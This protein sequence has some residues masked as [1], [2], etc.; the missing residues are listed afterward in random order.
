M[1]YVEKWE[2]ARISQNSMKFK[3][4]EDK[5]RNAISDY[6]NK[7]ELENRIHGE[8]TMFL[9]ETLEDSFEEL[10]KWM[11]RYD[12]DLEEREAQIYKMKIK[13]AELVTKLE[14]M[15]DTYLQRQKAIDDWLEEKAKMEAEAERRRKELWAVLVIQVRKF[16]F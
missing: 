13:K 7:I 11:T 16:C 6:K 3:I 5:F 8:L 15:K 12:N 14:K 4:C 2:T 1:R 9:N 10:E